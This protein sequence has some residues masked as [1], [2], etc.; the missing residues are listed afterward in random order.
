MYIF[1][2]ALCIVALIVLMI[3]IES[4][5][6]KEVPLMKWVCIILFAFSMLRYLTLIIY[7]DHPTLGQLEVLKPLYFATSIGLTIPLA[8]TIW[9]IS[10]YLREKCSYLKYL[11]CFTPWIIFYCIFILTVPAQ[12]Q[13]GQNIG[14]TLVLTRQFSLYLSIAQGTFITIIVILCIIGFIKYKNEYLRSAYIIIIGACILLTI[15]GLGYFISLNNW[16]PP[17]TITEIGGFMSIAYALSLK[18]MKSIK[19]K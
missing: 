15:D 19:Y 6:K 10:P 16:I 4:I 5:S 3:D 17:F 14:Y 11:L 9:F 1:L 8:S 12:I 13:T 7:G 18:P 2:I